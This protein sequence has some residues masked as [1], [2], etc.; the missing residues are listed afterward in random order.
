MNLS[1]KTYEPQFRRCALLVA[2]FSVPAWLS[3]NK[4]S[5]IDPDVWWHLRTGQWIVQQHWV[6]YNDWFS[7]WGIGK[8][9]FAYSWLFE[10]LIYGLVRHFG[11]IGLQI[12]VYTLMLAISGAFYALVRKFEYR[13][14]HS[15]VFAAAGV[16]ALAHMRTPRPWLFTILFF[17]IELNILV[18]VRRSRKYGHLFLLVPLFVLWANLHIQFVYGL[19]VLGLA[20][21]DGPIDRL[22]HR[23][24][25]VDAVDRALPFDKMVLVIAACV[26]GTVVNPYHVRI[27]AIVLDTLRLGG[28]YQLISELAAMDFRSLPDWIVL[29][30]AMA[31]VF[32]L[33]R[34]RDLSSFWFLLMSVALFLSLR[35]QRDVWFVT[36][37]AI[38]IISI[39]RPI[40]STSVIDR[41]SRAQIA[42]VVIAS[43]AILGLAILTYRV[44]NSTLAESVAREYPVAAANFIDT[45]ELP[46][47]LYNQFDW[48][49]YLIW[50]LPG[51]PVSIDGRSNLHDA[52]RVRKS[53]D[54]WNG[55]PD[56][57]TDPELSAARIIVA[58][59]N[60]PL[61]QLLR[62]DG[63]FQNIYEDDISVVFVRSQP[64]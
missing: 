7:S 32:A 8:P 27:Y 51:L 49:G 44:S 29:S 23:Q 36:T 41:I 59:R 46:G 42:V 17:I 52:N 25:T 64:K 39:T 37:V 2:F 57:D 13:L 53:A 43:A 15:I 24:T 60:L 22:L 12:Y 63:R 9:W 26:L 55:K 61:T 58:E 40:I 18:S 34:R 50:R 11:L 16:F 14:A 62:L 33:G 35:S 54:V 1:L 47:P 45:H 5:V 48:G 56:W 31:A 30:L 10:V 38:A 6:P 28:L 3:F 21:L 19:F 20:A 4:N